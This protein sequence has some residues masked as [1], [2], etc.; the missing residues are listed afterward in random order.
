MKGVTTGR[1]AGFHAYCRRQGRQTLLQRSKAHTSIESV[2]GYKVRSCSEVRAICE[3]RMAVHGGLRRKVYI[4][5]K[6]CVVEIAKPAKLVQPRDSSR[7][8]DLPYLQH[9]CHL[10]GLGRLKGKFLL[11]RLSFVESS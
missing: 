10:Q 1:R 5:C 2:A 3:A 8:R 7:V 9:L 6:A 4:A 11:E